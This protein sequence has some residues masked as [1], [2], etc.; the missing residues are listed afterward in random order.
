[1]SGKQESRLDHRL[2]SRRGMVAG[3]LGATVAAVSLTDVSHADAME[4]PRISADDRLDIIELMAK[5]AWSYDTSD[6]E[7]FAHTFTPDGIVEV[8]GKEMA[9]GR[10]TMRSFLEQGFAMRGDKGWQHLTDHHHF[11]DYDGKS[12]TI[13]SYY[14]MTEGDG[15]GANVHLRAMGYYISHCVKIDHR[16]FFKKRA[17]FRWD[18]KRPW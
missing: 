3:T 15:N 6:V 8:F 10:E 16:W 17:V 14:F 11:R 13:Y 9:R 4:M 12:C 7:G 1:M 2:L 5:Y 18:G